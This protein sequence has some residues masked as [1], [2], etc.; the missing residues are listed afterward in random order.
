MSSPSTES[1]NSS[2]LFKK[3]KLPFWV[4]VVPFFLSSVFYMSAFFTIFS[5]LP[6]MIFSYRMNI[7][8][9]LVAVLS[10]VTIV[11][12]VSGLQ[13]A[14]IFSC[15]GIVPGVFLPLFLFRSHW[16]VDRSVI[17]TLGTMIAWAG[18]F[19]AGYS[20][21]VHMAPWKL[22]ESE[23]LVL[24]EQIQKLSTAQLPEGLSPKELT[25]M[26]LNEL[27][28][29]IVIFGLI[30]VWSNLMLLI[31]TNPVEFQKRS[32]VSLS[33]LT[34]W[35][36]P[37]W[38]VWPTIMSGALMFF[39]VQPWI[40]VVS[41]NLFKILMAFYALQGLSILAFIFD[42]LNIFGFLRS[43]IYLMVFLTMMPLLLGLGF[44]DLWFDFREKIRR[45]PV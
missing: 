4:A 15:V 29:G 9:T 10:N 40:T 31:R 11:F 37:E 45:K 6:L 20:L 25:Q 1:S 41:T 13:S 36:T 5:S 24:V 19:L 17:F 16:S 12:L 33:F 22:F 18:M 32:Q 14:V 39:E 21:L 42:R 8:Q 43:L 26:V 34:E 27:P 3:G 28:S 35:K 30:V 2:Q 7:K 44:F 23:L 38:F